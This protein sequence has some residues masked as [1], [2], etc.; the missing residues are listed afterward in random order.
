MAQKSPCRS[1][2]DVK[3]FF[4]KSLGDCHEA[5]LREGYEGIVDGV[6]DEL[7]LEKAKDDATTQCCCGIPSGPRKPEW[8]TEGQI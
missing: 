1:F 8:K 5:S 6:A 7:G 2:K 4:C 3:R